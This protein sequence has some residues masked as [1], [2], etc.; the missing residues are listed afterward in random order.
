LQAGLVFVGEKLALAV[1]AFA[2][3]NVVLAGA[4]LVIVALLNRQL[5]DKS[6]A[7]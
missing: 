2:G 7:N 4:W 6:A 3:I 1:T 5:R